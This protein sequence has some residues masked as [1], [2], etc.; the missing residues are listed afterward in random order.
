M[1]IMYA[2]KLERNVT[3][4]RMYKKQDIRE[5]CSTAGR[6]RIKDIKRTRGDRSKVNSV[7]ETNVHY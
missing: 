7:N 3:S 4:K 5:D 1:I 6:I 2:R